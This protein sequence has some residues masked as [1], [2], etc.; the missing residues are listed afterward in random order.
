MK[1]GKKEASKKI[2]HHHKEMHKHH[3][4]EAKH[5]EHEM[6]KHGMSS[7]ATKKG[8]HEDGK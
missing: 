7:C 1:E 8:K 5:H 4:K 3:M 6:K 2:H